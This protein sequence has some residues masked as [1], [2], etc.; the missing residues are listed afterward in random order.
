[1]LYSIDDCPPWY[2]CLFLGLQHSLTCFGANLTVALVVAPAMCVTDSKSVSEILGTIFF[3][4][5]LV[6]LLQSTF[7]TRL[8]IVQGATFAYLIPT[9]AI[10]DLPQWRCPAVLSDVITQ[11][12]TGLGT[13]DVNLTSSNFTAQAA[14]TDSSDVWTLR[15]REI[16]GAIIVASL[17]EIILGSSGLIG[18]TLKFIGPLSI[19]PTITL[20]GMSLFR[21]SAGFAAKNWYIALGTSFLILLF[22]QYLRYVKIPCCFVTPAKKCSKVFYPVFTLFPVILAIIL[23]WIL[24]G[25][26]TATDAIPDDSSH[27]SYHARTDVKIK[28]VSEANWFRFPYP[29]QWGLPT[30]SAGAV[31][32]MLAGVLSGT[33]ESIGDYYACARLAGAPPPPI[34]AINRGILVEGIGCVLAGV[35]G[36]GSGTTSYSENVGAIGITKVASRRVIQVEAIY[37]LLFGV[38]GKFGAML[39]TIPDPVVGGVFLVMF[40]IITAVGVSNLQFVDLNSS[41]NLCIFGF[42]LFFGLTLP[43]WIKEDNNSSTINTGSVVVDQIFSVLLSTSM[44]VGGITG[45]ILDNTIPGTEKERG[46]AQWREHLRG[47]KSPSD[48][49]AAAA[50]GRP[51]TECY[52]LPCGMSFLRRWTVFRFIP[53][54]PTFL[55]DAKPPKTTT[56]E[57][58]ELGGAKSEMELMDDCER[59]GSPTSS[60]SETSV[61]HQRKASI[62]LTF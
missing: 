8:P 34:H 31:L 19:A 7:G 44:F 38:L 12:G 15:M 18:L 37:M 4:S 32:G 56:V 23:S 26:L 24:C 6:T 16:Q 55:M 10:L 29:F 57:G 33:I 14:P 21:A 17:F 48:P 5:G 28:V 61:K 58:G 36:S 40:G 13:T 20:V 27:W 50:A 54:C 1:M 60:V 42:S 45:F 25:I 9:F 22:S 30:V 11:N 39:V 59:F 62:V 47:Q 46:M 51:S 52:D 53:L 49:E 3:M 43:T 35:W 2:L 41:R